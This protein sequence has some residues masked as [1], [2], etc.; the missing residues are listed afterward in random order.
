MPKKLL[1]KIFKM[2]PLGGTFPHHPVV[3]LL[4]SGK[5]RVVFDCAAKF[6]DL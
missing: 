3:N 5:L 4:K 6:N 2:L 1:K